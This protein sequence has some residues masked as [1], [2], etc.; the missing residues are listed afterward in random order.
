MKKLI[1]SGTITALLFGSPILALAEDTME[2]HMEIQTGINASTSR[3]K[4]PIKNDAKLKVQ[5]LKGKVASS[6]ED[7]KDKMASTSMKLSD[8]R[9]EMKDRM[10]SSSENR[11][12]NVR[13]FLRKKFD[14]MLKRIEATIKRQEEIL[15]KINSRILKIK[16]GGGN[17]TEAEKLTAEAKVKIDLAKT[18][19]ANL[20]TTTNNGVNDFSTTTENIKKDTMEKMRASEKSIETSLKQAHNLLEKALGSL[21]GLSELHRATST[22][23]TAT[24]TVNATTTTN[25][26]TTTSSN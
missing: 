9:D 10:A 4:P 8:K 13:E 1:I 2:A 25:S 16:A 11:K 6:M 21:R 3:P 17:T 15:A 20:S 19:F 7:R 26:G 5:D 22:S 24:T 18:A 12:E 23:P 14:K